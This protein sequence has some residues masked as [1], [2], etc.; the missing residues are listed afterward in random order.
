MAVIYEHRDEPNVRD[1]AECRTHQMHKV[2]LQVPDAETLVALAERL[3]SAGVDHRLW[4]E[5]PEHLPTALAAK[6]YPRSFI[7][8]HFDGLKLFR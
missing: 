5:E 8:P 3:E 7:K 6:P 1:Y 2:V 4:V